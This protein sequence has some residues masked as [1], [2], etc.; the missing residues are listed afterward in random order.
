MFGGTL[1]LREPLCHPF[2]RKSPGFHLPA[3]GGALKPIQRPLIQCNDQTVARWTSQASTN[4]Q[5][6]VEQAHQI[7]IAGLVPSGSLPF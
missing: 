1:L 3:A 2:C 7:G 4:G 6:L 5:T